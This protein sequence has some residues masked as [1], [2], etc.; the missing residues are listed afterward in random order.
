MPLLSS[1]DTQIQRDVLRTLENL[2]FQSGTSEGRGL[3]ESGSVE[4]L[5]ELLFSN[6]DEL[7][8]TATKLVSQVST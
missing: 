5:V 8:L 4:A 6:N 3:I 7:L 2:T 1:P